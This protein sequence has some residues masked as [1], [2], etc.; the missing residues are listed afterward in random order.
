MR[1]V[2]IPGIAMVVATGGLTML[3]P[4][5]RASSGVTRR[6]SRGEVGYAGQPSDGIS[7]VTST[8]RVPSITCA[9]STDQEAMAIGPELFDQAGDNSAGADVIVSCNPGTI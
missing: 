2:L 3:A 6:A 8:F 7:S 1:R 5:A 4:T 9:Q